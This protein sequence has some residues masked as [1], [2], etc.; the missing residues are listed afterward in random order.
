MT[1]RRSRISAHLMEQL[2]LLKFAV[3]KGQSLNFTEGM[4]W[5]DELATFEFLAR[6][7][8]VG[9]AEAYGRSLDKPD[10]DSDDLEDLM[11]DL[12]KDLE[13]LEEQL[14]SESEPDDNDEEDDFFSS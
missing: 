14:A 3:R 9:D 8:P 11:E 7:Q 4:S 2:Q 13:A 6:T 5:K 1:P 10:V 12:E